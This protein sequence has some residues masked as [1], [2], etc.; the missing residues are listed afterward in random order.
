MKT[1]NHNNNEPPRPLKGEA[2]FVTIVTT[3][4]LSS[5]MFGLKFV[6]AYSH[7]LFG[8]TCLAIATIG[9]LAAVRMDA[10]R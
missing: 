7:A 10:K 6:F 9:I 4:V 8:V 3:V 5:I 1:I 2:W